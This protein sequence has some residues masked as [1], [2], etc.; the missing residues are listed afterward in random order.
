MHFD[1]KSYLKSTHNHTVKYALRHLKKENCWSEKQ[2]EKKKRKKTIQDA[3]KKLYMLVY[4]KPRR[5][6]FKMLK[7]SSICLSIVNQ[8]RACFS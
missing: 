7:K 2:K 5:R 4:C 6:Q 8:G 1:M 3:Q